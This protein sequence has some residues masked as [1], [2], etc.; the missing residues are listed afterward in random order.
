M[1]TP[2]AC[3]PRSLVGRRL[4]MR[5]HQIGSKNFERILTRNIHAAARKLGSGMKG[6]RDYFR[7]DA[8]ASGT[9]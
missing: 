3:F 9:V 8:M 7:A 2:V 5:G 1:P 6:Y 4:R